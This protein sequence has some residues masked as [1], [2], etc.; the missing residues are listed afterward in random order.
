M[1][2][3][4]RISQKNEEY[5]LSFLYNLSN[6]LYENIATSI[7]TQRTRRTQ[8]FAPKTRWAKRRHAAG[9]QRM[10]VP[11]TVVLIKPL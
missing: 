9:N 5:L 8:E 4:F 1:G 6:K 3:Y 10:R 11:K 2:R 7:L